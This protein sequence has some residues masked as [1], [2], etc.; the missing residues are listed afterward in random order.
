ML[1]IVTTVVFGSSM[2]I[3]TKYLLNA[4]KAPPPLAGYKPVED[5]KEMQ[6]VSKSFHKVYV[7]PNAASLLPEEIEASKNSG[8]LAKYFKRID[9]DFLRPFF[10]Y[11][12]SKEKKERDYELFAKMRDE[13][14]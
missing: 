14:Q 1:V 7:H 6:D 4:K 11:K 10:I 2:P 5:G 12:Y 8:S 3:M 9:E 13:G